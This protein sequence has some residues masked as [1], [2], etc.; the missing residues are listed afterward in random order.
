MT[1][2]S[3]ATTILDISVCHCRFT[4]GD[5]REE[6]YCVDARGF[7]A[8]QNFLCRNEEDHIKNIEDSR[9]S[10]FWNKLPIFYNPNLDG[11]SD[12]CGGTNPVNCK[13]KEVLP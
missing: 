9:G 10:M 3:F 2:A 7:I 6:H 4:A 1:C 8:L 13:A 11:E 12:E 5:P